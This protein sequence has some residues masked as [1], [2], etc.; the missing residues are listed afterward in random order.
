MGR[1]GIK[2]AMSLNDQDPSTRDET[3]TDFALDVYKPDASA[4]SL[5]PLR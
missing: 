2:F 3:V 1:G 5:V 4:H